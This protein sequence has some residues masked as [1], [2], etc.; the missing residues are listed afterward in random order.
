MRLAE[1][2]N[3]N[4]SHTTSARYGATKFSD[5]TQEEFK[6]TRCIRF[7]Y[8]FTFSFPFDEFLCQLCFDSIF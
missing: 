8:N 3:K 2:L 6:G 5:M 7:K 1:L 4:R